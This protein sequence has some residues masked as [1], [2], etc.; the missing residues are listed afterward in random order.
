[1]GSRF[2]IFLKNMK[3]NGKQTVTKFEIMYN[4]YENESSFSFFKSDV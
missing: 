1:M 2:N 3:T 4:L